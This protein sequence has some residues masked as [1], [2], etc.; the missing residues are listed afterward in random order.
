MRRC[1]PAE[2]RQ[3]ADADHRR[4]PEREA[5]SAGTDFLPDLGDA[6]AIETHGVLLPAPAVIDDL[7]ASVGERAALAPNVGEPVSDLNS[8]W[9]MPVGIPEYRYY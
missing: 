7:R 5:P 6:C 1:G 2:H 9:G 8:C 4:R 3:C